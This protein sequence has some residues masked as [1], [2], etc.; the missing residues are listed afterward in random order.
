[1]SGA[2]APPRQNIRSRCD[3]SSHTASTPETPVSHRKIWHGL[4]AAA[5]KERPARTPDSEIRTN[6]RKTDGI[7]IYPPVS[8]TWLN[9]ARD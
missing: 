6:F 1:M 9:E 3:E 8:G 5:A 4:T 2:Y 7:I